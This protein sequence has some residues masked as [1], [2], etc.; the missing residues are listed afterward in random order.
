MFASRLSEP[1][2]SINLANAVYQVRV[3]V[4]DRQRAGRAVRWVGL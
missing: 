1:G 2:L 4:R 3:A